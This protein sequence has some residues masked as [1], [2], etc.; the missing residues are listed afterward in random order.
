MAIAIGIDIG[1]SSLKVVAMGEQG[2]VVASASSAYPVRHPFPGWDEQ[3]VAD[4]WRALRSATRRVLADPT[5]AGVPVAGIGFSGQ[6]HGAVL[7]GSD[8]RPLRPAIIWSDARTTEEVARIEEMVPIRTLVDMTGNR[9]STSFTA[10]K[11]LW[12]AA[13]EPDLLTRARA[14]VQPKDAVRCNLTGELAADVSDASATLLF[15]LRRRTWSTDLCNRLGIEPGLLAPVLES[16]QPAGQV[17][18]AAARVTGLPQGTVVAAGGGDAACSALGVGLG[19]D[20]ARSPL[21]I[22]LGT[23][24]QAFAV[25]DRPIIEVDGRTHGLCYVAPRAWCQMGAILRAG[26][27]VE[28][29]AAATSVRPSRSTVSRLF[30]VAAATVPASDDPMFLPYLIGE[31]SPHFDPDVRGAFAGLAAHHQVGHLAR[32]VLEGVAFA[33][34]D[35]ADAMAGAG[36]LWDHLRVSGGGARSQAWL[37]I[38][39]DAFNVPVEVADTTHGSARGAAMLGATAAGWFASV[40]EAAAA[41]RSVERVLLPDPDGVE[42]SAQ[43][44]ARFRE[45]Y[46]PLAAWSRMH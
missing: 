6:M 21:L 40:N 2:Q 25:S 42:R 5:A 15:D 11:I 28:W 39:A 7:L 10:S 18:R 37:Q 34:R 12:L 46:R 23:A 32:A 29:L 41:V 13:H 8:H 20:E 44:L 24:G 31:R 33:L 14:I 43:R 9:A 38:I 26:S 45:L 22:T 4:W 36:V 19:T 30:G 16:A 3:R 1:T 27:A 17:S 35:A